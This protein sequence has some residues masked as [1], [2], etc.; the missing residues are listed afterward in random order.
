MM[1]QLGKYEI[2]E[3]LGSGATAE[4]FH[5]RDRALGRD[6]ALKLL[7]PA[8]VADADSFQRFLCEASS[9]AGLFHPHIVTVLD[10]G[11][12]DGR[13]Y[14]AMRYIDGPSLAQIL[15][16]QG[17]L[18]LAEVT[19]L[20]E[21][22]GA[23]LDY[24]H[25]QGFLHRD[26][27]PANILRDSNGEYFLA[28]FG[29]TKAMMSTGL[30]SHT[31][32]VLGTP[33]YIPPEIWSGEKASP[34]SDQ[35]ALACVLY[36]ALTGK[37]L[38]TGETPPAVMT[39]HVL[40]E[41]DLSALPAPIRAIL[42]RALA[43]SVTERF[44]D[45]AALS[46]ALQE[47]RDQGEIHEPT[48]AD[49]QTQPQ[50]VQQSALPTVEEQAH[51]ETIQITQEQTTAQ[52]TPPIPT[53]ASRPP[54]TKKKSWL[55]LAG[56]LMSCCGLMVMCNVLI[57][58]MPN[59][60]PSEPIQLKTEV[61]PKDDRQPIQIKTA[62][63]SKDNMVMVYV[64]AGEFDMGSDK[65]A[66]PQAQDNE[67]PQHRVYLDAYWI[68]QTEVTNAMYARCVADGACTPPEYTGSYTRNSYYGSSQ[69]DNYPVIYVDWHQAS[70]YCAWA[71]RRL[72][73]E[74]EWEKAARGTDGRIYPWGDEFSCSRG[75][76]DDE[77]QAH[78]KTVPGGPNCDGFPDTAPVGSY[79]A[80]ASPYGALDLAGNVWEWVADWYGDGYYQNSPTGNP[81]GP[82]AGVDRVLRGGSWGN[83]D[84][85][86]RPSYRDW[87]SPNNAFDSLGFRCARSQ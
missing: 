13:Y 16:Q 1:T 60:P 4:V 42:S 34:A 53:P 59:S 46:A 64:P 61:A 21:Q 27:K 2:L 5:A 69:F 82:E 75:N 63:A 54:H 20:A 33:P 9:A 70:A 48:E 25:A 18:P 81:V 30:T 17:P 77:T 47:I 3:N 29:L 58:M 11:E 49:G 38:F 83:D 57:G 10:M 12:T 6:V 68:D 55:W 80:G 31:G 51:P 35:Y 7:K 73:T 85:G 56:G 52:P 62:I 15:A 39:A 44:P 14:I 76:F 71:G 36:E 43:K 28:D 45:L 37:V 84:F 78:S 50:S 23:A 65:S 41:P 79:P 86:L 87:N 72:P 8:L 22:I 66:D 74:A 40:R 32:A 26:V 19:R 24:A 67:L